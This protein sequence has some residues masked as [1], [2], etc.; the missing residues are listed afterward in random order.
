MF[1]TL[2]LFADRLN[3]L[4]REMDQLFRDYAEDGPAYEFPYPAVNVWEDDANLYA[5]AELPGFKIDDVEI[6]VRGSELSISGERKAQES[7]GATWHRR[8]RGFGKFHRTLELPVE[9]EAD[10]VQATLKNGILAVTLPKA[11][12]ARPRKIEVKLL[13]S[14]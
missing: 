13:E 3:Q 12:E 5:E 1:G 2:S 14:R 9:I 7:R 11:A 6:H 8:E 4:R 10:K